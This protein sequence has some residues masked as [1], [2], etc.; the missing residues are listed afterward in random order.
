MVLTGVLV[1]LGI[2]FVASTV[3]VAA[4]M[5]IEVVMLMVVVIGFTRLLSESGGP[6][7]QDE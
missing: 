7:G 4:L 1:S 2:A 6:S 5:V 3:T